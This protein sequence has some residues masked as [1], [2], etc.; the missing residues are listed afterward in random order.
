MF[1][2]E[3]DA[4]LFQGL[5]M[6]HVRDTA[7]VDAGAIFD[8]YPVEDAVHRYVLWRV[9]EPEKS[10]LVCI[11]L[12]PSTATHLVLDPTL[13]RD[14]GY[15]RAWGYGGIVKLNLFSYRSTDPGKLYEWIAVHGNVNPDPLT[16]G[17][18]NNDYVKWFSERAG[19]VLCAWGTHGALLRR[20]RQIVDLL[21]DDGL[22]TYALAVTRD[23]HPKHS[24][25]ARADIQ[26]Q[27]Y[28]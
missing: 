18:T 17:L 11:G 13:R 9:W 15:A 14:I 10:P 26:P 22:A 16:G 2:P 5:T 7:G 19:M 6:Q 21:H 24:L 4:P 1:L 3:L 8:A 28:L 12:N 20:G 25:Y 27:P 23:G